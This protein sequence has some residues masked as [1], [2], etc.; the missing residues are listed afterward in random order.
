V[1]AATSRIAFGTASLHLIPPSDRL[2][3]V[4]AAVDA[5]LSYFDTSPY[6]GF[7]LAEQALTSLAHQPGVRIATKVGLYPPGGADQPGWAVFA[8]KVV[9]KA[10]PRFS[11]PIADMSVAAARASL[12]G[13]RRRLKRDFIDVVL[14][15]EPDHLTLKSEQWQRFVEEQQGRVGA[16]GLAGEPHRLLA[17]IGLP[18]ITLIQTRD[19]TRLQEAQPLRVAGRAPDIT[20]G[21]YAADAG[22]PSAGRPDSVLA[23]LTAHPLE[24]VIFSSRRPERIAA[25]AAAA[26]RL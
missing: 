21:H 10:L 14:V 8:R 22:T 2:S 16:F 6:Y 12:D 7:G 11:K 15:H 20:F 25:L 17:F 26:A 5:G 18:W 3:V 4:A 24:M 9:G 23:A 19:S 1:Q 13:S